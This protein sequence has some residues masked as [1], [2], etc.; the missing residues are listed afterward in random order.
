MSERHASERKPSRLGLF[1]RLTRA[2]FLPLII[3]PVGIGAAF[4]DYRY[5]TFDLLYF[6]LAVVG[7]GALHL[8]ANAID[9]CYDYENGVDLVADSMFPKE[10]GG[11]KPLPRKLVTL[12]TARGV[13]FALLVASVCFALYFGIRIGPPAFILGVVGVLLA[14]FYTAPPLKLDYRG[15]GLGELAIFAAFGPVPVLGSFYIQTGVLSVDV[16]LLSVPVGI[17]TVTILMDHDLIFFEVYR[18]S[19]KM[20]LGAVL[21]R[22]RTQ[23]LSLVLTI[24]SYAFVE[25]LVAARVI[26]IWCAASP[27]LSGAILVRKWKSFSRPE[28]PPPYYVPL[29]VSALISNWVFSLSLALSLVV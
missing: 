10:F 12:K 25:L 11:W 29:T 8:G 2:Q 24:V 14:Y 4:A 27:L 15:I 28:E 7:S 18:A 6:A 17:L 1:V 19:R 21:G 16:L 20:S 3:L 22:K 5:H 26:P 9:D 13:S 23:R